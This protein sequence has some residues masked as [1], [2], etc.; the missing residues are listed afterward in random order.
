VEPL[1][2]LLQDPDA[3]VRGQAARALARIGACEALQPLRKLLLSKKFM[4]EE[5]WV[6]DAV[7]EVFWDLATLEI[8]KEAG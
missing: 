2:R 6:R 5:D 7:F 3:G 1:L 8:V 4:K